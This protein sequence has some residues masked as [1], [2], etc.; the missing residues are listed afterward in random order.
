MAH[1]PYYR[2]VTP[3][4]FRGYPHF[5]LTPL[6]KFYYLVQTS[7]WLHQVIS[8]N[9]EKRRKDFF[10]MFTHHII[11]ILLVVTSYA[12]NFTRVGTAI[13]VAMDFTDIILPVIFSPSSLFSH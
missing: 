2:L 8:L 3:E 4:L 13:L 6:T 10:Q 1:S 12:T 7:F 9:I 5:A 11:T